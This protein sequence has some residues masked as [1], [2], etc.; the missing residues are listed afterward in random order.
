M[1]VP[2]KVRMRG[3]NCWDSEPI[4]TRKTLVHSWGWIPHYP[5]GP[6][7]D[8]TTSQHCYT[9]NQ[10]SVCT[11]AGK[12]HIQIIVLC[13]LPWHVGFLD[14]SLSHRN[15]G[16]PGALCDVSPCWYKA[17]ATAASSQGWG[18]ALCFF[19]SCFNAFAFWREIRTHRSQDLFPTSF[20]ARPQDWAFSPLMGLGSSFRIWIPRVF[21][22]LIYS[23]FNTFG[24]VT[25]SVAS[26][27]SRDI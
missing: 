13:T 20:L 3:L 5:Q 18:T 21:L 11:L 10:A 19:L 14:H 9:G 24:Y 1:R 27:L 16:S 15:K 25:F 7:K 23:K 8:P 26:H 2:M 4:P 17:I 12:N 6:A 22:N